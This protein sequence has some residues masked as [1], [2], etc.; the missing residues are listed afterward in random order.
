MHIGFT[1][2]SLLLVFLLLRKTE[3]GYCENEVN[4]L[5]AVVPGKTPSNDGHMVEIRSVFC[6][7]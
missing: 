5:T 4:C 6:L 2:Y 1:V 7:S 3:P